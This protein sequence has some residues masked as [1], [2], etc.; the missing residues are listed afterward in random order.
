MA[1][2]WPGTGACV[3]T[4]PFTSDLEGFSCLGS[5]AG[6]AALLGTGSALVRGWVSLGLKYNG[7]FSRASLGSNS[8]VLGCGLATVASF[9]C[10]GD[11]AASNFAGSTPLARNF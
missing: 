4:G 11:G 7:P 1:G 2:L 9:T 10:A 8:T 6:E 3:C 5:L